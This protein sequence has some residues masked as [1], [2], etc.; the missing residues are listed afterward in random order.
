MDALSRRASVVGRFEGD[1]LHN[2]TRNKFSKVY[3]MTEV[4]MRKE[5]NFQLDLASNLIV[6]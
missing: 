1:N 5:E 2:L 6:D 4:L 3:K